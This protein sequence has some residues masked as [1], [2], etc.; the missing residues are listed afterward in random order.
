MEASHELHA[1]VASPH[2]KSTRYLCYRG[3]T[4]IKAACGRSEEEMNFCP[5]QNPIYIHPTNIH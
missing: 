1:L 4:G 3:Q 5:S 2:T